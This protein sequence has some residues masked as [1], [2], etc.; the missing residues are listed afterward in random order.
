MVLLKKALA[1]LLTVLMGTSSLAPVQEIVKGHE[2]KTGESII[3][4][5]FGLFNQRVFENFPI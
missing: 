2:E 3:D 5:L 1:W 4:S